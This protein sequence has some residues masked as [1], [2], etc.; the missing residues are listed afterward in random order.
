VPVR[1][2]V[3]EDLQG[4]GL[5]GSRGLRRHGVRVVRW[6][7]LAGS[8]YQGGSLGGRILGK[9]KVQHVPALRDFFGLPQPLLARQVHEPVARRRRAHDHGGRCALRARDRDAACDSVY[10]EVAVR[11]HGSGQGSGQSG[12]RVVSSASLGA[13][14]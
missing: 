5:A 3:P 1:L 11:D 9:P 8:A 7:A 2:R 13:G 10:V 12:R 6:P 4:R 14:L